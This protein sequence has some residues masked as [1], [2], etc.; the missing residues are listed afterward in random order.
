MSQSANPPTAEST[1][2]QYGTLQTVGQGIASKGVPNLVIYRYANP[3]LPASA[4]WNIGTQMELPGSFTLDV[5]Y[6][7]QHQYD[8]QGAQGGQQVTPLNAI[9]FGT[10]YL[11]AD[12]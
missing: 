1:T 5:S 3:N 11:P 7:G 9:D 2:L 8:S 12:Q 4:Q 10:A 6:V